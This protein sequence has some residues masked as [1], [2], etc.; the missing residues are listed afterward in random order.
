M[1]NIY[2]AIASFQQ[3]CPV[4]LKE[5]QG[6]NYSYADL[7][8]IYEVIMPLLKK[9]GLGFIQ[10]LEGENL[11]TTL[12]HIESGEYITSSVKIPQNVELSK[13][14]PYQVM[15]SAISYFRRYSISSMLGLITDKDTDASGEKVVQVGLKKLKVAEDDQDNQPF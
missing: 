7:P 13:M 6:Y 2:K 4:I 3:E 5:T 10:P 14:N 9:H 11:T 12:F 8:S 1:K 15:G